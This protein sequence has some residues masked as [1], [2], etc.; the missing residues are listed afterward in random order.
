[1][2]GLHKVSV[3][4]PRGSPLGGLAQHNVSIHSQWSWHTAKLTVI[5]SSHMVYVSTLVPG[6]ASDIYRRLQ[7]SW[8]DYMALH[9]RIAELVERQ[10]N[11]IKAMCL[12]MSDS[13]D[14]PT[15]LLHPI[16]HAVL[17]YLMQIMPQTMPQIMQAVDT[18]TPTQQL[19]SPQAPR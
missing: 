2:F 17:W 5:Q 13:W 9:W 15:L 14:R 10:H 1:M 16:H 6:Q 7:R 12:A 8:A 11:G 18:M 19:T 4:F 3:T